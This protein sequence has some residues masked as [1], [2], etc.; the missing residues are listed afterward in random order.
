T[1]Q[2]GVITQPTWEAYVN[3]AQ[4]AAVTVMGD[5]TAK[6]TLMA[7][8]AGASEDE[9]LTSILTTIGRKLFRRPLTS[10]EVEGFTTKIIAQRDL[11]T[12]TGSLDETAELILS[13]LLQ[14]PS[15]LQRA[16]IAG[17]ANADGTFTLSQHEVAARLSFMLWGSIPDDVL[18]A[19]ADAGQLA[20]KEQVLAQAQRML[21]HEN[22]RR[23][24]STFHQGYMKLTS[25]G[26]WTSTSKDTT[27]YPNF[28]PDAVGN[29]I[30]EELSLFDAVFTSGGTFQDL[31]LTNKAW[32]TSYTAPLYGLT[33]NFSPTEYTEDRKS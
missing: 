2:A 31:L 4:R 32:V 6:A 12:A 22:A 23:V 25:S 1:D 19:A 14:S 24:V 7:C 5:A 27:L 33:G 28:Q 18:D 16:E 3:T 29:M 9:C 17:T 21:Q 10:E 26:R 13:T 20:T 30:Y 15:F 8:D 11:V